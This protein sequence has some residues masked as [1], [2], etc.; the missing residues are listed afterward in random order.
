VALTAPYFHDASAATLELAVATMAKYQLGVLLSG[1]ELT[2]IVKFLNT[3][4]GVYR[5]ETGK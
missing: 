2:R 4:T 3:L 1:D 5:D